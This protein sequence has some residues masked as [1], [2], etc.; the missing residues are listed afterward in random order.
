MYLREES[1]GISRI[2][3]YLRVAPQMS[4]PLFS[5]NIASAFS[6]GES[7]FPHKAH[8][9]ASLP[10]SPRCSVTVILFCV[11]VPVLSEQITAAQP[12]V[13]TAGSF[14]TTALRDA[15]SRTPLESIMVTIAGSPSGMAATA[16]DT[17]VRNIS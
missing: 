13:S 6:V 15:I 4:V 16:S 1:N 17:E 2:R 11:R 3:G 7:R 9:N 10:A 5:A 8:N 12:S 14:F